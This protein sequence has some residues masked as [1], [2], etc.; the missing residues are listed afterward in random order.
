MDLKKVKKRINYLNKLYQ[1]EESKPLSDNVIKEFLE[2][3]K[4][5]K[6]KYPDTAITP[7][8]YIH[9]EW[10]TNNRQIVLT[11]SGDYKI[12]GIT[13]ELK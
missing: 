5:V 7:A 10:R 11:F 8:G 13:R 9:A 6:P 3:C 1:E 12:R 4:V 2:F